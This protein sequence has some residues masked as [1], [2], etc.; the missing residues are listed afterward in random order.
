MLSDVCGSL[1]IDRCVLFLVSCFLF[2]V[3]Y[4]LYLV[5]DCWCSLCVDC[6]LLYVVCRR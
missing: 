4:S 1:F 3:G 2:V 6:S 5:V